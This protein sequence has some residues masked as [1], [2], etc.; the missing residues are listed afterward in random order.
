MRT[1][2]KKKIL[3]NVQ[4]TYNEIAG[5][6]SQSR[7]HSWPEFEFF[8]KY[9]QEP[10][11]KL[12]DLG[13]GNGR[14]VNFLAK[15]IQYTGIDS[16]NK[17]IRL[18]KKN[19]PQNKFFGG[20][21]LDLS[22]LHRKHFDVIACIAAFHH[23]PSRRSRLQALQN[24]YDV[25]K[26]GGKLI[27]TVWNLWQPKYRKYIYK[28]FIRSLLSFGNFHPCDTFIPWGKKK[29]LRYYHSFTP[30]E[31]FSLLKKAKFKLLEANITK[32]KEL[33]DIFDGHNQI[34]ICKK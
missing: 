8:H 15:D 17:L 24:M 2:T 21:I 29:T 23:I 26:P 30:K 19:H 25:L 27:L 32:G 11:L 9:L 4:T 3:E 31:M 18:A 22:D 28:A 14:L 7:N 34:Y 6:F 13:C 33:A 16:S 10:K 5:E 12:L 20:D 1:K